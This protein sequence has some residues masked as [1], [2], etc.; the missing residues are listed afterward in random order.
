MHNI[1]PYSA[2]F[3]GRTGSSLLYPGGGCQWGHR[4]RSEADSCSNAT[5]LPRNETQTRRHKEGRQT[6][7]ASLGVARR[8]L[9]SRQM[10]DAASLPRSWEVGGKL[11]STAA[12]FCKLRS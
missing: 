5:A 9:R 4:L 1:F 3:L 10:S 8:K 7:Q 12:S 6:S 2:V 11:G